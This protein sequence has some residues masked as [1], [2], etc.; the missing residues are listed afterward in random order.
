MC[1]LQMRAWCAQLSAN[2]ER[3]NRT[4]P[5]SPNF[6]GHAEVAPCVA[7]NL[8]IARN[9]IPLA[10]LT[11]S[12]SAWCSSSREALRLIRYDRHGTLVALAVHLK[13]RTLLAFSNFGEHKGVW[14]LVSTKMDIELL[15]NIDVE[16]LERAIEF[17]SRAF[18]LRLGRRLST[19]V[20]EMLGASS[21]VYLLGKPSGSSPSIGTTQRRDYRRHW[22]P[23]HF[24]IVVTD[25]EAAVQQANAA[26]ARLEI[27]VQSHSWGRIA[28]MADPFGNGFCLIEFIGRGYDELAS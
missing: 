17:Y 12:S 24:D 3:E 11:R 14:P 27:E 21:A 4:G 25:I 16:D 6:R 8:C 18:D 10:T 13:K 23:V 7:R 28:N 15:V 22:T 5:A 1:L 19:D 9:L 2:A 20:A 26:G